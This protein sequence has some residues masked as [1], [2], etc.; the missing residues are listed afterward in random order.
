MGYPVHFILLCPHPFAYSLGHTQL[1]WTYLRGSK[2]DQQ[3][4]YEQQTNVFFLL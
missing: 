1:Y 2:Q 4:G 3:L